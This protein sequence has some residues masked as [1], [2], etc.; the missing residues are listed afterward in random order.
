MRSLCTRIPIAVGLLMSAAAA[1]AENG[2]AFV[3]MEEVFQGYWKTGR[4]DAAFK[5]QKDLYSEHRK[6]L[7]EEV[8]VIKKQR[9]GHRE[10]ALNIALS[11]DVRGQHRKSAEESNA[12]YEEKMKELQG[13]VRKVDNDLKKRYLELRA[14]IVGEL[15]E[16]IKDYGAREGY[17]M[18]MDASGMTHNYIPVVIYYPKEQDITKAVLA[19]LNQGHEE[20]VAPPAEEDD[21]AGATGDDAAGE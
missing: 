20:E 3:N 21:E 11:D 10:K 16:F 9:D 18:V 13:F 12:L 1:F 14:E 6:E 15:T 7:R 2:T 17:S 19:E 4:D 5:K 8:D